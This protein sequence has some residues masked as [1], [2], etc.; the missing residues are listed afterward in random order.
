[1]ARCRSRINW[2]NSG[3]AN[4]SLFHSHAW[5]RKKKNFIAKLQT[6]DG[7]LT[8][9]DEKAQ[10]VWEFYAAL[11]GTREDRSCTLD[12]EALDIPHHDLSSLDAPISEEEVL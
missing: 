5:Y 3:D 12:L 2:L 11:L 8:G 10:A 4:T 6:D 1:V 9:H 7:V